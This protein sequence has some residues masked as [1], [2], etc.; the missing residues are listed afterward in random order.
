V[1]AVC[2]SLLTCH[3]DYL[4][5]PVRAPKLTDHALEKL[6][7]PHLDAACRNSCIVHCGTVHDALRASSLRQWAPE[8][9]AHELP[10][11]FPHIHCQVSVQP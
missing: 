9:H 4:S 3:P 2:Q 10:A 7:D 6:A 11:H 1:H 8:I 5:W